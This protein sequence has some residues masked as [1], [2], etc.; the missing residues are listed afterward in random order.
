M[1]VKTGCCSLFILL[2]G[3]AW[4]PEPLVFGSISQNRLR[5]DGA[6]ITIGE[7]P[8]CI[9]EK[10]YGTFFLY[11][12]GSILYTGHACSQPVMDYLN[13]MPSSNHTEKGDLAQWGSLTVVRDSISVELFL[14]PIFGRFKP[15]P[16]IVSG[17]ITSDTSF[18]IGGQTYQFVKT[19]VKPDSVNPFLVHPQ[20][21]KK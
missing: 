12:N 10:M 8:N 1:T 3:A 21:R 17:R 15:A 13:R 9:N 6:Y 2:T 5:L 20:A 18:T 7:N 11:L 14:S 19:S 4:A 16:T